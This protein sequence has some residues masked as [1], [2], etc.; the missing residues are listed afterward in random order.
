MKLRLS[1]PGEEILE[2]TVT[3]LPL[4][5]S[6]AARVLMIHALT[7]AAP[8]LDVE[9]LPA[10]DDIRVMAAALARDGGEIDLGASGTAARFLTA[11]FA[12]TPG[13]SVT[14]AG[15]DRL[16]RR[17]IAPLVDALRIL[18]A[19]II[20]KDEEGCLPIAVTGRQL[21]GGT[22]KLDASASS[23]FAS[24]LAMIAPAMSQPLTIDLGGEIASMPYLTMTLRMLEH[25][26]VDSER[27]G[28]AIDVAN[29][30]YKVAPMEAESD[31]SAAAFWYE[32]AAVTAGW[33]TLP[34]LHAESLQGDSV[35]ARI[36]ERMGVVSEFTDEGLELSA[37][38]DLYSRLDMD[39]ADFPDLV[40]A[41]AVTGC[42]IGV[43][44]RLSGLANL[45][46]KESDRLQALVDELARCGWI[47]EAGPDYLEWEGAT[48]PIFELPVM[49][50]HDDHRLAMA[51]APISVFVPGIV[52]D[53]AEAVNKS[54]P[55]F[56][57]DLRDAGFVIE[58]LDDVE[59]G[60]EG[61]Q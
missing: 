41:V 16:N 60:M 31:W 44:Y 52:I 26:G 43:P 57:D 5:K 47:L 56:W 4:S 55:G 30:A 35:L 50:T 48:K 23:Q 39:M 9:R 28:Y 3:R 7:P 32:I 61:E 59:T 21:T 13:K 42:M 45:R 19:D 38:P 24:A 54:Y 10:C 58:D 6:V 40:P 2:T 15:T 29:T 12:A 20:Y 37:T 22:V 51:F 8:A 1:Y 36:G 25:R 17:P 14:L 46:V 27:R 33:I 34:G 49:N 11:Y 18:G 53:G